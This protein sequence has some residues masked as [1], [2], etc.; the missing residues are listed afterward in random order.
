MKNLFQLMV[1]MLKYMQLGLITVNFILNFFVIFY[2][3][4]LI[5]LAHAEA[6][7][8][9][10]LDGKVERDADGKEVRYPVIL[11]AREKMIA[12][13]VVLAFG[14]GFSKF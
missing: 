5:F 8:A 2:I 7:K 3:V 13:R 10:G 6:R 11:S 14:V 4:Y 1:L 9:P 12:R